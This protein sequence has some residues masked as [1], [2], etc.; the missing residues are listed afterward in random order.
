MP[1]IGL[2]VT[3][4]LSLFL[5]PLAAEAQPAGK[6]YRIGFLGTTPPTAPERS[7]GAF[8]EGLRDHGYVEGQNII[9]E[10]RYSEGR[11][12]A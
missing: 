5:A 3:L 7:W 4:T 2:A 9:T 6:V 12:A 8:L 1:L 10:R 11:A